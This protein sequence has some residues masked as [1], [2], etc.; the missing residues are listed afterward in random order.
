MHMGDLM[1]LL[2]PSVRRTVLGRVSKQRS[3]GGAVILS[4][5]V[6]GMISACGTT[7]PTA[8]AAPITETTIS[9]VT[10]LRAARNGDRHSGGDADSDAVN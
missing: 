2:Y 3:R 4:A 5:V 9:K 1:R 8:V 7:Q 10:V 6:A